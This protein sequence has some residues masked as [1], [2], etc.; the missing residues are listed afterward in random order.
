MHSNHAGHGSQ[1]VAAITTK[2]H[3]KLD[4]AHHHGGGPPSL[5]HFNCLVLLFSSFYFSR[6]F[7]ISVSLSL[8]IMSSRC[9][10]KFSFLAFVSPSARHSFFSCLVLFFCFL[11]HSCLTLLFCLVLSSGLSYL[12]NSILFMAHY[13]PSCNSASF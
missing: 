6:Y 5:F 3:C 2:A 9:F 4:R 13:F 8:R 1:Y 7:T 12:F 10:L 11:L